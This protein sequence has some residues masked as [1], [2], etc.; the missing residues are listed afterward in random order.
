M[1]PVDAW[2]RLLTLTSNHLRVAGHDEAGFDL[3]CV[4]TPAQCQ[5][6]ELLGAAIPVTSK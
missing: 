5:V 6:F 1:V 2:E 4:P 3:L